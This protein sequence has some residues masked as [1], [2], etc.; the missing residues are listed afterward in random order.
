MS[1]ELLWIGGTLLGGAAWVLDRGANLRRHVTLASEGTIT[2]LREMREGLVGIEGTVAALDEPLTDWVTSVP[3]V[4]WRWSVQRMDHSG[5]VEL[6]KRAERVPF[7]VVADGAEVIVDPHRAQVRVPE[8]TYDIP[9]A[10]A[11]KIAPVGRMDG[12]TLRAIGGV[13]PVG[14][15][16]YVLG[17][18]ER[19]RGEQ[20]P[21][22]GAPDRFRIR[23]RRGLPFV[24][25]SAPEATLLASSLRTAHRAL[26]VGAT[27][28]LGGA[29]ALLA[30]V[31]GG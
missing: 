30:A 20:G 14:A 3:A 11:A 19:L 7:R 27:T 23:A 29:A 28:A 2:N 21:F 8:E 25:S 9:V 6:S 5:P 12:P 16:V 31:L 10:A 15:K 1:V 24:V 18:A 4:F 22:R 26:A 13:L 17:V